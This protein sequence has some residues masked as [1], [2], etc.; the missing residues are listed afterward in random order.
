MS[1]GSSNPKSFMKRGNGI[2]LGRYSICTLASRGRSLDM[3]R[4]MVDVLRALNMWEER[5]SIIIAMRLSPLALPLLRS[6]W[7]ISTEM[8]G[9]GFFWAWMT[10]DVPCR[11]SI[12]PRS[13]LAAG[14][15]AAPILVR[16]QALHRVI[17]G[18]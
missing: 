4:D 12:P 1:S 17:M 13:S 11:M 3:L 18:S 15:D 9:I 8:V 6:L 10:C 2:S 7:S 5:I 16:V 14:E